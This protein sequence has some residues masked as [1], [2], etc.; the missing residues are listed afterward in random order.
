[1]KVW[2]NFTVL[3]YMDVCIVHVHVHVA[4]DRLEHSIKQSSVHLYMYTACNTH[5]Y[6]YIHVF[7]CR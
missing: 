2:C 6:M 5:M 3:L 4:L 7:A 1:M